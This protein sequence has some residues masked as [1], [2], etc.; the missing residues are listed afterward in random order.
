[1][2]ILRIPSYLLALAVVALAGGRPAI[3]AEPVPAATP[4]GGARP[5]ILWIT[6]EDINPQLGCFG[7][8]YA[9]TPNLDRFAAGAL[10]YPHCWSTA[11][12]CAPARTSIITGVYPTSTGMEHMRSEVALPAALKPYPQL[13]RDAGYYCTNNAKTDYNFGAPAKL[14]DECS[15]QAHWK[16]RPAGR[17]FLAVFNIEVSHESQI[18]ARP[19]TLRHDPAKVRVPAYHPDT[20][21]VRHDWA[22]YYDN[23]TAMD[24]LFAARLRELEEAGLADDTL[25]LF[26]GD[27][28]GGMPRSKRWP[29]NSGLNVPLIVRVPEKWKA[30]APKDYKPGGASDRLV[31][32][33]DFAP[34]FVSL[35]GV[36]PPSWMQGLAFLGRF[37]TPPPRYIHGFRGRM[38]ERYDMVRS[39][40]NLRYIY[41]RNYMPHL[42]YGQHIDYMF[43]TPTTR[44]WKQMYDEGKLKPPQTC[45]WERKPPE[46]LYDLQADPDEVKNLVDSP[47]HQAVLAELRQ[48]QREHAL[49]I[50]DVGFLSE[51]EFHRRSAG[52][53]PY[54]LGHDPTIYPLEKILGMAD[55]ASMLKP[56]ALPRLLEGFRD[57]DSGV[58]YWA[59]MGLLMRG[60]PAVADARDALRAALLDESPTVRVVAAQALGQF[61]SEAD[62][63]PALAALKDLAPPDRNGAYVAVLALSAIE[64]LGEKAGPLKETLKTMPTKDPKAPGRANVYVDRLLQ[65]IVGRTPAKPDEA[66]P[67]RKKQ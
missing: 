9:E 35:A 36:E 51:A 22:Q 48:A 1:M 64:A 4:P 58:R 29:Y 2:Q 11:P 38:D 37:E 41:I 61:G 12:V 52:S 39:V 56:E 63:A 42:I 66:A 20:P 46:E 3:A 14:W 33:V 47:D 18:R 57:A 17:P 59:A 13:L 43:Q 67:R 65:D 28:G 32:F 62:L 25:V 50:R 60:A 19:H 53:T 27:N 21:E 15:K 34:T 10:R 7:D 16:N 45:F 54:D 26:C 49:K 6:C 23:I 24:A 55:A 30:L 44:V 40:R 31:G 5:N 8:T